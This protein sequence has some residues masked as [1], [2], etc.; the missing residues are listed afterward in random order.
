MEK[1]S[2]FPEFD[3]RL[4]VTRSYR[5]E[6]LMVKRWESKEAHR[7]WALIEELNGNYSY[8]PIDSMVGHPWFDDYVVWLTSHP[9]EAKMQ[10]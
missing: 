6:Y 4:A 7:Q 1:Q 9:M 3:L 5:E 10:P 2:G 8:S